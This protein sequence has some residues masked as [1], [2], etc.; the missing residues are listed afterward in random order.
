MIII[1]PFFIK[2]KFDEEKSYIS[3]TNAAT[4]LDL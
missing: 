4:S 3:R 1:Y 2:D